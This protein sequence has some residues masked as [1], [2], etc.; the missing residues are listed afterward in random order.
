MLHVRGLGTVLMRLWFVLVMFVIWTGRG[1]M[2][3]TRLQILVEGGCRG[4]LLMLGGKFLVFALGGVLLFLSLHR[5][6]I[7]ISRAVVNHDGG[8]GTPIDPMV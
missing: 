3:L 2:E 5:F 8:A 1:I 7:A 4:G 6:F